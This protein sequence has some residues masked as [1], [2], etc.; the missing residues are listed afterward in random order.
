MAFVDT[1]DYQ[2]YQDMMT[3]ACLSSRYLPLNNKSSFIYLP[4]FSVNKI[5]MQE[6]DSDGNLVTTNAGGMYFPGSQTIF[7]ANGANTRV[8]L[9]EIAHHFGVKD[10][11]SLDNWRGN[12]RYDDIRNIIA[13]SANPQGFDVSALENTP[14]DHIDCMSYYV[15]EILEL[16]KKEQKIP[17]ND[18]A[19]NAFIGFIRTKMNNFNDSNVSLMRKFNAGSYTR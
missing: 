2:T 19:F 3:N 11:R 10:D 18:A 14:F 6:Q 5:V 4:V 16:Y 12:T 1:L 13:N 7:I 17:D 8:L 15:M 9:H